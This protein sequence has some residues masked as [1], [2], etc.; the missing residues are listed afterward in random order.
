[1]G[2]IPLRAESVTRRPI[3]NFKVDESRNLY[4]DGKHRYVRDH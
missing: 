2:D 3:S 1:M 4:Y